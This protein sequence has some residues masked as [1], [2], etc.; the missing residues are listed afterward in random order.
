MPMAKQLPAPELLRKLLRY[1]AGTGK[2]YWRTRH[3]ADTG[4]AAEYCERWNRRYAGAEAFTTRHNTGHLRGWIMDHNVAAQRVIWAM[5]YGK[6][7]EGI[8]KHANGDNADNRIS[9]LTSTDPDDARKL[10]GTYATW[11]EAAMAWVDGEEAAGCAI[12]ANDNGEYDAYVYY[13]A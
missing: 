7:P 6:W 8:I 9:N 3:P 5:T 10:I 13:D 4:D 2:L 12:V 1:D 11:R